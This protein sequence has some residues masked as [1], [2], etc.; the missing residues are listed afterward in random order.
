MRWDLIGQYS[1]GRFDYVEQ[2]D[3]NTAIVYYTFGWVDYSPYLFIHKSGNGGTKTPF[4]V[5]NWE[6]A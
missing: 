2:I 4:I 3:G 6:I 5:C 1:P